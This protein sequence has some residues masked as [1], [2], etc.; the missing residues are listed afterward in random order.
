M[1]ALL[2][3]VQLGFGVPHGAEAAVHAAR[4][5]LSD[6]PPS[7]VVMKLD[8][9]NAFNSIRRDKLLF[10]VKELAPEIFPFVYST[11]SSTSYLRFGSNTILSAESIQQGDPLGPLLF[12]LTIHTLT[13]ALKSELKIFYLDDG[14]IGGSESDVLE[15][16]KIIEKDAIELGLHLNQEKTELIGSSDCG[17][18]IISYA[19]NICRVDPGK[20][21]LLGTPIGHLSTVDHAML[22]KVNKLKVLGNRLPHLFKQDALFLI[23]SALAIPK[24]LHL[25]RTAPCF[26]SPLLEVFDEELCSIL[27]SPLNLSL[28]NLH[29]WLQA[30]LPVN[31]GGLGVRR[32]VQLAPSAFLASATA[33]SSLIQQL[34][35][36]RL[37]DLP[38]ASK[39]EALHLWLQTAVC[40]PPSAPVD[41]TQRAWDEP[42]FN[43]T[44]Q[45]LLEAADSKVCRARLLAAKEKESSAWIHALPISAVGL[46]MTDDEVQIAS[47]LRLGAPICLPHKCSL[48]GQD[49]NQYATHGLSCQRSSGCHFR[50]AAIN[51]IIHR[52]L[53]AAN[54]PSRLEPSG[55]LRSDGKRPDGVTVTPWEKGRILIWDAT[56]TDTFAPSYVDS[57]AR[58]AGSVALQAE[59]RK[60]HK[61]VELSAI[62]NFTPVA[63]ET[64]GV[65]GPETR[66][67]IFNLASRIRSITHED[68]AHHYLIQQ[69]SVAIQ[70]G[71]ALSIATTLQ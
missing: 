52:S 5:Y 54:I 36:S 40:S 28:D 25:L 8:F 43:A 22:N 10:C 26:S 71:N 47:A 3:P 38:Y 24:T 27:S 39:E 49:V 14:T 21:D 2:S 68:K 13:C 4:I 61:Y 34:L 15:D 35:P 17:E 51:N 41:K 64:S 16:F 11:Y 18:N 59:V 67:F 37:T 19:P 53:A 65:F 33:S 46:R 31:C 70:K 69:L 50:H 6:L 57:A 30:T 9:A 44:Y 23:R 7:H 63:I 60:K 20:A 12:C 45:S 55:L 1:A 42:Q 29:T 66:D 62:H 48:C 32:S 56:C 58:D